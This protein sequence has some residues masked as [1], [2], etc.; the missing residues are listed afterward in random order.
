MAKAAF[1]Q[2]AKLGCAR[3]V[4]DRHRR[5]SADPCTVL[6]KQS[7]PDQQ[8]REFTSQA[9]LL[10]RA[11]PRRHSLRCEAAPGR[12]SR[13]QIVLLVGAARVHWAT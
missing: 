7:D 3:R 13:C 10:S 4:R 9:D 6:I 5:T 11:L 2:V 12:Q 1:S 8:L